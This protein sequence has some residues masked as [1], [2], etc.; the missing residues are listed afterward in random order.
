MLLHASGAAG[1]DEA[2]ALTFLRFR[3]DPPGTLAVDFNLDTRSVGACRT[4]R[5]VEAYGGRCACCR[6]R[7]Y[8]GVKQLVLWMSSG[9]L[10]CYHE[11][12]RGGGGVNPAPKS[13]RLLQKTLVREY[14]HSQRRDKAGQPFSEFLQVK[15]IR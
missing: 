7:L 8:F 1:G 10:R 6:Y 14:L 5:G 9:G 15:L 4:S 13:I 2:A 11:K 3:S 12:R